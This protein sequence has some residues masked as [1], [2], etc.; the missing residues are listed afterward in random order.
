MSSYPGQ[1][2]LSIRTGEVAALLLVLRPVDTNSDASLDWGRH[3]IA[4]T[5][6][7]LRIPRPKQTERDVHF[8]CNFA[9]YPN[10]RGPF[11]LLRLYG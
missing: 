8:G 6:P 2:S 4:R 3:E 9:R 7:S 10:E 5:E 11:E 1:F